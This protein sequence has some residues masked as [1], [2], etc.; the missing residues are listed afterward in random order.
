MTTDRLV[1]AF[2]GMKYTPV[3]EGK[4]AYRDGVVKQPGWQRPTENNA[5]LRS[6]FRDGVARGTV[7][8]NSAVPCIRQIEN[9]FP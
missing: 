7:E 1:L 4:D 5:E 2:D 8:K 3:A 6:L 9:Q